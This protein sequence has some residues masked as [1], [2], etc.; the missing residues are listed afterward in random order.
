MKISFSKG[1]VN[2]VKL[3][4]VSQRQVL[5]EV[6]ELFEQNPLHKSLRNH[7]LR[8][9]YKAYRSID[10][11]PDLRALFILKNND[12]AVF[13]AVGSHSRLYE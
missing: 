6:I 9:K 10:V 11:Q 13:V 8:G 3:L 4:D 1:F 7:T 2:Q 12:E 5:T